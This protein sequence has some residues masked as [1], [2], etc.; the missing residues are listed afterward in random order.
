MWVATLQTLPTLS[1]PNTAIWPSQFSLTTSEQ[2][3]P[4]ATV[5]VLKF[6]ASCGSSCCCP[7]GVCCLRGE[8]RQDGQ[9]LAGQVFLG[10]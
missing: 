7:T 6:G 1:G 3:P 9:C 10:V 4:G 5:E 2:G 8:Q